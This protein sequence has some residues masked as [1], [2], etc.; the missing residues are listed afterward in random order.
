MI[1]ARGARLFAV[2]LSAALLSAVAV[3][4]G[5][6][7]R[8][9][10][11]LAYQQDAPPVY[12]ESAD[13]AADIAAALRAASKENRRVLIQWGANWCGWC[14]RLHEL[15]TTDREIARKLQYEYDVVYVDIGQWDKNLEV[16][17]KY[18]AD[19][20]SNGVP[21]LTVLSSTGAVVTHQETGALEEGD[22]H[23][24]ARVM[25][26]LEAYQPKPLDAA[27]VLKNAATYATSTNRNL[28]L[29]IGAPWCG[30]CKRLERWLDREAVKKIWARDF[31]DLKIDQ[32]RMSGARE[33]LDTE[34]P[35]YTGQ[36]IPWFVVVDPGSGEVLHDSMIMP[37]G[38]NVGCPWNDEEIALFE[39]WLKE[40]CT[41]ITP[42]EQKILIAELRAEK[43]E[44]EAAG[45]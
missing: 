26:F 39:E 20:K 8:T 32:D 14:T 10:E 6:Q 4:A 28:F 29:H 2:A 43:A 19:F 12:D 35:E 24:P 13:A 9:T 38:N 34:F 11:V 31:V 23:D 15:F 22:H 7:T 17:E 45:K 5:P 18:G 36:G 37:G 21:Y 3:A 42:E 30:W 1:P 27:Y 44:E 41:K 16:A 33:I 40:A 25:A